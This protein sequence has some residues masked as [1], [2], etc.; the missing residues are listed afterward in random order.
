MAERHVEGPVLGL[1]WDGVGLGD[2][3]AAWGGEL[4]LADYAGFRRLA[5]FRPI[6]LAGGDTAVREIWRTA[7]AALDDAYD[8][9]PPLSRIALF[10]AVAGDSIATLRRMVAAGVNT[11][12]AHGVGRW[13]DAVAAIGLGR[14][15]AEHEG[16]AAMLWEQARERGAET[17]YPFDVDCKTDPWQVDLRRTLRVLVADLITGRSP[18]AISASFHRTLVD[19][20]C[21]LVAM[22]CAQSGIDTVVLAG[23]CFANAALVEGLERQLA[24]R[25]SVHRS[26]ALPCGDGGLALG[27]IAVARAVCA[28]DGGDASC[29]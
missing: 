21:E 16:Q 28:R 2:D 17:P 5:T 15:I 29:V 23:G 9:E 10:D 1:A 3:G 20:G 25:Y 19:V 13:F 27:Q 7:L 22:A 12:R 26:L 14:T 18:A 6:A 4:L 11:P 8:G 24:G